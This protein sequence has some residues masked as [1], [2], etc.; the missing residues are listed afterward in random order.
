M[1]KKQDAYTLINGTGSSNT[2]INFMDTILNDVS[3]SNKQ[4]HI[5]FNVS[6]TYNKDNNGLY[7]F[8]DV[9]FVDNDNLALWSSGQNY[10][11]ITI[12]NNSVQTIKT[13]DGYH[14]TNTDIADLAQ[15]VAGWLTSGGRNYGSVNDVL[16]SNNETDITALIA[17]FDNANWQNV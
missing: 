11:G 16:T 17:Q 15:S 14:L 2:T 8:G 3:L 12:T 6:N 7:A 10:K 13:T 1:V 4:I 5:I 9:S